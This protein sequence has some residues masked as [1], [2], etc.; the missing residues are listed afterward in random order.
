VASL[1]RLGEKAQAEGVAVELLRRKPDY[2]TETAR[3]ELF[4]CNDQGFIDR[5]TEGLRV[6]GISGG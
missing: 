3:Q 4:F 5:F 2:S 6:A 1:G